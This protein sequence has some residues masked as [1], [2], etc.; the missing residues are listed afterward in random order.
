MRCTASSRITACMVIGSH[1]IVLKASSYDDHL[2]VAGKSNLSTGSHEP[3][4]GSPAWC[5]H[6]TGST[7][8]K[9]R[10]T[11]VQRTRNG[12]HIT[13]AT[14]YPRAA[15]K[16]R[17]LQQ[18]NHGVPAWS[19]HATGLTQVKSGI[20]HVSAHYGVHASRSTDYPREA[21]ATGPAPVHPRTTSGNEGYTGPFTEHTYRS[22]LFKLNFI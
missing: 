17:G 13:Q 9:P 8:L 1:L 15:Y 7:S 19:L 20:T 6:A 10:T 14:G 5:V 18:A 16:Q 2:I 3:T 12:V 4:Q 22:N 11:R 21:R